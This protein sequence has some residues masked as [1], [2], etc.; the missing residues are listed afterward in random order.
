MNSTAAGVAAPRPLP[1]YVERRSFFRREIR[2]HHHI[3]HANL[4]RCKVNPRNDA[5]G[6]ELSV[7]I[8]G[9]SFGFGWALFWTV[10]HWQRCTG[11]ESRNS[12]RLVSRS[13]QRTSL[14]FFSSALLQSDA[15]FGVWVLSLVAY[16]NSRFVKFG[17]S[18]IAFA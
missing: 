10:S 6:T 5:I 11:R 9:S 1:M 7:G 16:C 8:C 13:L 3:P 12:A 4:V 18:R 15:P 14:S 2:L 17:A